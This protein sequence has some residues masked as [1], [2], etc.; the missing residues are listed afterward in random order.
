LMSG[1]ARL[2]A[3]SHVRDEVEQVLRGW[4]TPR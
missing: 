2:D 4:S 3:R 1:V